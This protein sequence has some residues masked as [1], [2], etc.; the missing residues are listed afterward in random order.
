MEERLLMR[1]FATVSLLL[2]LTV[3]LPV[4]SLLAAVPVRKSAAVAVLPASK[5]DEEV[6]VQ[7]RKIAVDALENYRN[8]ITK[9]FL[10]DKNLKEHEILEQQIAEGKKNV[11]TGMRSAVFD[12]GTETLNS[13]YL[14]AKGLLGELAPELVADL[15]LGLAMSKAV[16]K[17]AAMAVEYMGLFCNLLPEKGRQSVAYNRL[18][19]DIYDKTRKQID[20]KRKY[21]V[22][23]LATPPDALIGIDGSNWG[24]SPLEAELTA[25]GHLVQVEAEGYYR[26]G[27]IKDPGLNG[28]RWKV[29][30]EPYESRERFL[31]TGRR[32]LRYY[33]PEAAEAVRKKKKRGKDKGL[34]LSPPA[35]AAEADR[36]L[37]S[38]T[39]LFAADY[40][41]FLTVSTEG[42]KIQIRGAFV[43]HFGTE[44][45][46]A[47]VV[48][49]ATII[50]TVRELLLE[51]TDLEK[52]KKKLVGLAASHKQ[53]RLQ[54]W[55]HSLLEELEGSERILSV[56]AQKWVEVAQPR[57]AE[58][59]VQ[60]TEEVTVVLGG[61]REAMARVESDPEAARKG[62]E[63][64]VARWKSLEPK[65]RSLLAWDIERAIRLKKTKVVEE[66][67][68]N[69]RGKLD[70]LS[71]LLDEKRK[72]LDRKEQRRFDK[73]L[74]ALKK[75][76]TKLDKLM[77][78]E[79]LSE[80]VTRGA[81]RIFVREAELR[82]HLG[83]R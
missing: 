56:R 33:A 16:L 10:A 83:L 25:G 37:R 74:R 2:A 53:E 64:S 60:T 75:E 79:P 28:T 55:G 66:M 65:V 57:K 58:L 23:I 71:L 38:L 1:I 82:R 6:S 34:D 17:E 18:F 39:D 12:R 80:S 46:S 32:L 14:T 35:D 4:R 70:A 49:D 68:S 42:D 72:A 31:K 81:Y 78:T 26:G 62:L 11:S 77:R 73:E 29:A 22:T 3:A 7:V 61:V 36:L 44:P 63:E 47:T 59:F 48:R 76:M 50:T 5:L 43:S 52:Q 24:K 20:D 69:A 21:K 45:I 15:F 67:V 19:L 41:L 30:I 27:W 9:R 13:A 51:A 8:L 40:L 54:D